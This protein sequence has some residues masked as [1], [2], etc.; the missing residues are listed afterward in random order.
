M[1]Q[2][3]RRHAWIF[4]T[5][6]AFLVPMNGASADT[7]KKLSERFCLVHADPEFMLELG[8]AWNRFDFCWNG[9][10]PIKGE[11][12]FR[13]LPARVDHSLSL[14]VKILPILD[15]E[16][17]WDPKHSPADDEALDYWARYVRKTITTFKGKM[18]YWQA[19]NEP[20]N[21]GFWQPHPNSRDYA[22]LLR[23]SYL[24]AKEADPTV[25][26]LGLNCSD[27]DLKFTEDVFRY[28]GLNYCD[29]LAYQPYRIAPEVGHFEE[30]KAL[31]ELVDK[32]GE[33]RPIWFTEM[34][35]NS[36]NFPFKDA[37]DYFAE[38]PSR[39]QAAFLVRYMVII[40]A[41]GIDKVFWFAQGAGGHGIM[42]HQ[43]QKKRLAFYAYRHLIQELDNYLNV[44]EV[45]PHGS[46]GLYAYLFNHPDRS[47]LVAWSVNGPQ[48]AQIPGASLAREARDMLGN[49]IAKPQGELMTLTGEPIYLFFDQAPQ[50]L[51][52]LAEL[53][54][55][56]PRLWMAPG[57]SQEVQVQWNPP[58]QTDARIRPTIHTPRSLGAKPRAITLESQKSESFRIRAG[59]RT[60]PGSSLVRVSAGENNWDIEVNIT[61]KT[62]WEYDSG[63]E[64][65]LTPTL[66]HGGNGDP[67]ILVTGYDSSDLLCLSPDGTLRWKFTAASP[68]NDSV[69]VGDVDG[70]SHLEIVAAMPAEQRVFV[71]SSDG[72]QK[73]R[74]KL[75]GEAV[76]ENPAWH[77]TRPVIADLNND[78]T[79]EILYADQY[80]QVSAVSGEGTIL[81]T[82]KISETG[83]SRP[84]WAGPM[85]ENGPVHMLVGDKAGTVYCLSNNGDILWQAAVGAEVS[86]SIVA[87]TLTPGGPVFVLAGTKGEQLHCLSSRGEPVWTAELGGTMDLG[88]GIALTD[89]NGDETKEIVVS[90][91]NHEVIAFRQDGSEIWRVETG[92][93][94]RSVPAIGDVDNDGETEILVGS[95]DWLL[96]CI[97]PAGTVEWTAYVGNRVDA[98]PLLVDLNADEV[99]DIVLPV[100]GGKIFAFSG[101]VN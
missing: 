100:R 89:L 47:V 17:A 10:E 6:C 71:L 91:R 95:A 83:F 31:R 101:Q 30:V 14:G 25:K 78:G 73:W 98:A 72:V 92:A 35:W 88:T 64:G 99:K 38:I 62:L 75:P 57:E 1:Y 69:A 4:L 49:P 15:Y 53:Q 58:A 39:R 94:L 8:S 5:V 42:V 19:W 56:P 36:E 3:G 55:D 12:D 23:R 90:S 7:E 51:T 59:K 9:I 86:A 68:I 18:E 50:N 44:R 54:V 29:I 87:G 61:P 41:V 40:Q 70:D 82:R 81:W 33:Q 16:P 63:I 34:G 37:A 28:G 2:P 45:I 43:G 65:C 80:G 48:E 66:I 11:F 13:D 24:A 77:W 21:E 32:Y 93:Q 84:I 76:K 79:G 74:V 20:N 52:Q 26:V 85:G 96:Y 97:D 60:K 27:I 46:C 67:G 22:E